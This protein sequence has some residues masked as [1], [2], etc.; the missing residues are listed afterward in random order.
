MSKKRADEKRRGGKQF[1]QQGQDLNQRHRLLHH[2]FKTLCNT[3]HSILTSWTG[4]WSC[5]LS[6]LNTIYLPCLDCQPVRLILG[7]GR[8]GKD[9]NTAL[10]L[11]NFKI[12]Y[13]QN[14]W[15]H[16]KQKTVQMHF[17]TTPTDYWKS[18]KLVSL[19]TTKSW[20]ISN[21]SY[22]SWK[23]FRKALINLKTDGDQTITTY[24]TRK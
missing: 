12:K 23:C 20:S 15:L 16:S 24:H 8:L 2:S 3:Q 6:C 19:D 5:H 17:T 21:F 1:V 11:I 9:M 14:V 7:T 10:D 4:W 13:P 22:A 18:S